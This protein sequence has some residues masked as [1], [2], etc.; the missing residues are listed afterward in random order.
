MEVLRK[1]LL[2][3]KINGFLI[4]KLE[5]IRISVLISKSNYP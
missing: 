4:K 2:L 3:V 1:R 5:I